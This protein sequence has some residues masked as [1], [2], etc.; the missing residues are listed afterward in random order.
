M[1]WIYL[2]PAMPFLGAL[3]LVL[4]SRKIGKA[5]V[6]AIGCGSIGIAALVTILAGIEFIGS[7]T[8]QFNL[9]LWNWLTVGTFQIG[10]T[11]HLDA[12]S[13]AFIFVITF[14]GFLIHIYS[15][16]YMADDPDFA[17]FFACMNLFVG[18]MLMLVLAD[19]LLLLYFGWEGVGL[20]S[21]LLIGFWYKDPANGAAARKAFI[22]TR[23]G[24]TAMAIA[25][26]LLVQHT[27]SLQLTDIL[28]KAPSLW[29]TG[30]ATVVTIA[31]LLLG[32][33]V[34]K[35]AQLPLQT[36]LPDAMAGPTPVSAL[37]HAATMV[38]AGVYL[39]ARTNILFTLSPAAQATVAI[40]GGVTLILAGV[41]AFVQTDIKRVLAYSTI[42]QIG[43][44]F[45]AL[46]VGA[47]SAAIFHFITHAFFKALLFLGAGA[48]I[49][50][51]HH[52]QDMFKMGGLRKSLPGVFWVFLIGSASLAAVPF[53]TAGF[54]SKDQIVWLAGT[55]AQGNAGYWIVSVVGAFITAMY[56]ARMV[57][58]VF[59][60]K[61]K[62]HVHHHPGWNMMVPLYILAALSTLAGFIELP[63][64][65]G[66]VTLLSDFLSPVL[67]AV[68]TEHGSVAMEWG[69]Q[70]VAALLSFT[71]IYIVWRTLTVPFP[72]EVK[73]FLKNGWGFDVAYD[74]LFV[75]PFVQLARL[76]RKDA[77]DK[78]Y[79]GLAAAMRYFHRMMS[80]TQS[81]ILRWYIMGI[82]MGAVLILSVIIWRQYTV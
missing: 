21:Y 75:Q 6:A 65:L 13:L 22:V 67:P 34:G 60:G 47:W 5:G 12:L 18:A 27:G 57:L 81:G 45:L 48:I 42:S 9:P 37:I 63:H 82:V 26:F 25:L 49:V 11:L 54:Y 38:T 43:Y 51:L 77:I 44:M 36:W 10:I 1:N 58:L 30:D 20:C 15:T 19:N 55:A 14:V 71:G 31:F 56:T 69:S 33:A 53:V 35:S 79:T 68:V 8:Q 2:V 23:V 76:N 39:I 16:G 62:T 28:S 80:A 66:H 32:G 4:L 70:A 61:E 24:D 73:T 72:K 64:T 74:V 17:R 7:G 59:F 29:S 50:A 78:L 41:S 40:V 46:G 3:L 52:E